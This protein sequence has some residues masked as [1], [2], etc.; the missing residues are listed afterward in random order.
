MDQRTDS[1]EL[2][3]MPARA[4]AAPSHDHVPLRLLEAQP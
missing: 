3:I 2:M 4:L 1:E